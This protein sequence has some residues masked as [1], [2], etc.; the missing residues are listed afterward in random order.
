M[1]PHPAFAKRTMPPVHVLGEVRLR[2]LCVDD[3]DRD[4]CAVMESAAEIRA[5]DPS[6]TWPEGLT[7]ADNLIDLAWHQ[8]EF[9]SRR[10]FAWVIEDMGG[11]YL[12]CLYV[13]PSITGDNSAEVNWWWRRGAVADD[14]KFR[15]SLLAWVSGADW[16]DLRFTLPER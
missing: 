3:L 11:E 5:A 16:P 15:E 13:Y 2:A 6:L 1:R 9:R 12:G 10:S 8:R 14:R 4:Y 7:R